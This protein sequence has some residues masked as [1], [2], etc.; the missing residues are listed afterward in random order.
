MLMDSNQKKSRRRVGFCGTIQRWRAAVQTIFARSV[1]TIPL[2]PAQ[3]R[4]TALR[5]QNTADARDQKMGAA[6]WK[7]TGASHDDFAA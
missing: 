7:R 2:H 4:K 5:L 1:W 6:K 3:I